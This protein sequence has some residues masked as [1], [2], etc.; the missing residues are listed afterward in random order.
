MAYN[1]TRPNQ[2]F[3]RPLFTYKDA[4]DHLMDWCGGGIDPI[5]RRQ[6]RQACQ[7]ALREVANAHRWSFYYQHGRV[8]T[9]DQYTTGTVA[10][11]HSTRTV[12]LTG[13]TWPTWAAY[14]TLRIGN[15]PYA[16]ASR[17]SNSAIVLEEES[18]P[19]A[20]VAGGESFSIY[21]EA[22]PLPPLFL[23]MLSLMYDTALARVLE[24]VDPKVWLSDRRWSAGV[25]VPFGFTI[26]G[27]RQLHG[28][29]AVWFSPPPIAARNYDCVYLRA[30]RPLVTEEYATGTVSCSGTTTLTGSSTAW[31]SLHKGATVRLSS[32]GTS[33]PTGP[34]GGNPAVEER[35]ITAVGSATSITVDTAFTNTLSGVKYIISDPVDVDLDVMLNFFLRTA[36]RRLGF[37]R[38]RQGQQ[39]FD[40]AAM[41]ARIEA[42]SADNRAVGWRTAGEKLALGYAE[43]ILRYG[44]VGSD[45]E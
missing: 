21:R 26:M 1:P 12:T 37:M 32:T 31:T 10:Y 15:V 7:E 27:S 23:S 39:A 8:T 5:G 38:Q 29:D 17:T 14:G 45:V 22:Y 41:E 30:A 35:V 44:G 24:F 20:D 40:A 6:A 13:G 42:M 16:V 43:S 19:G 2:L 18:N 25:G 4:V 9:V 36:E 34:T 33:A 28:Q 3:D 11:T